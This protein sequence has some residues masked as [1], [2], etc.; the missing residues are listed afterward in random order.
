MPAL[1]HCPEGS[2]D[3]LKKFDPLFAALSDES[4]LGFMTSAATNSALPNG[5]QNLPDINTLGS[6]HLHGNR[7]INPTD[8]HPLV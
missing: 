7:P 3:G 6:I 8:R 2:D 5:T 4:A 1:L